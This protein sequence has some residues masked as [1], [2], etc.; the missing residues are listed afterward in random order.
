MSDAEQGEP[1]T[2]HTRRVE[3]TSAGCRDRAAASLAAAADMD[4]ANAKVRLEA[5]AATWTSR[6]D[7][8]QRLE[9]LHEA[10]Q[11]SPSLTGEEQQP[12]AP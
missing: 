8:L 6:A 4:T 2:P 11:A 7:L 10:R 12:D 9:K 5:S 1:T 3:D